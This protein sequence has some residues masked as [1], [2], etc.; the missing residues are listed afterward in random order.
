MI[1]L[2]DFLNS[3]TSI[4]EQKG[5]GSPWFLVS[6]ALRRLGLRRVQSLKLGS[7]T[8]NYVLIGNV[9]VSHWIVSENTPKL[10]YSL[11]GSHRSR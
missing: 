2:P 11:E 8:G 6:W 10:K 5:A 1:P 3:P 7:P 9:E 4:Y